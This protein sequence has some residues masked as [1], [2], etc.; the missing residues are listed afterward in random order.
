MEDEYIALVA[1]LV[2]V[3]FHKVPKFLLSVYVNRP[4]DVTSVELVRVATVDDGK[5]V[6]LCVVVTSQNG[7][8]LKN[9]MMNIKECSHCINFVSD[10]E[11]LFRI[12]IM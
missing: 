3:F 5:T 10:S 11:Q 8:S 9:R 6:N 7:S 4:F 2:L 12:I 1:V